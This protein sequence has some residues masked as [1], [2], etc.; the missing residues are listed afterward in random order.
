MFLVYTKIK[1]QQFQILGFE[2]YFQKF[3]YLWRIPVDGR[4]NRNNV[5]AF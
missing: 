4:P 2:E 1:S 5:A 3:F